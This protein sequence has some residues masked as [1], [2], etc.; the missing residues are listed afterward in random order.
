MPQSL[1][2][3]YVHIIFGTKMHKNLIDDNI[4]DLL[5]EYLGGISKGL[6][7]YPI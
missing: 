2:K 6:E 1:S 3:V 4:K 5:F 7:C